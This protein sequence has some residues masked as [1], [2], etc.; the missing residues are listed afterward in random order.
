MSTE[1]E[2]DKL[3][4]KYQ[5]ACQLVRQNA[6]QLVD[7]EDQ[8]ADLKAA[9]VIV[10]TVATTVQQTVHAKLAGVV[11]HCLRAVFE[12]PYEFQIVFEMKRGRTEAKLVFVR[13][14]MVL[15]DPVHEV[16]GGVLEVAAFAL[17]VACLVIEKPLKR[18]LLVL[19]EPFG[20]LRGEANRQRMRD[21]VLSLARDFGVQF[22]LNLD[23]IS[24]PEFVLGD[25]IEMG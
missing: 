15:D 18:R 6:I 3:M 16:G 20:R 24:Y 25:V 5:A 8:E 7:A 12:D 22:I 23:H 4:G 1:Q 13:R 10:Q 11:T 17:R 14:G 19:D 9:R 2:L 21:L